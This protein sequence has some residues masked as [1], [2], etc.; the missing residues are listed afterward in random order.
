M[1]AEQRGIEALR[2]LNE[3]TIKSAFE[4]LEREIIEA[5]A[6]VPIKDVE[7]A[8]W[9]RHHF[10]IAREFQNILRGYIETGKFESTQ[11]NEPVIRRLARK[12]GL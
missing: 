8:E 12:A 4:G 3:P 10:I 1:D 5:M 2:I 6:A 7:G 9:L 11:R